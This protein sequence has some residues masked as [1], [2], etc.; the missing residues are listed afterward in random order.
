MMKIL[1]MFRCI[2]IV[3]RHVVR[4]N[5]YVLDSMIPQQR[6]ICIA[7][8]IA[9]IAIVAVFLHLKNV[10]GLDWRLS[11]GRIGCPKRSR[12]LP[13]FHRPGYEGLLQCR[14]LSSLLESMSL[15]LEMAEQVETAA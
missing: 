10:S 13:N 7:K 14:R 11:P 12:H 9:A 1:R 8:M 2:F 4:F 15:L 6:I 5:L 3:Y